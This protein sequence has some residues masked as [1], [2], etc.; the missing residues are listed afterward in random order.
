MKLRLLAVLSTIIL[1]L[2]LAGNVFASDVSA[3]GS[4]LTT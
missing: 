2:V 1:N 3:S 4:T